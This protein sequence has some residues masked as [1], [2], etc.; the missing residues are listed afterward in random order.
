MIGRTLSHYRILD[1]IGRGGMGAVYRARDTKLD[2]DVAIKV[3]P[4]DLM[5]DEMRRLRFV[6]EAKAAAAI[7]NPHVATIHEIDEA[8]GVH[9]LVM[10]FIS[11]E[12]L[13]DVL[14]RE[15][16]PVSRTLELVTELAE[17]L[18]KAHEKRVV[19]RDL[20]PANVMLTEDGHIKIIDFGLAKLLESVR[21]LVSG[22]SE[23]ETGY[24]GETH[25][26]QIL[27]TV[28]YM[29]P[30]QAR[31]E[32]VDHRSD[33]FSF[34]I[35]FYEMLTGSVPFKGKSG[36]D[37][38]SAI[39]R[40]PTPRLSG[41]EHAEELQH[42]MN[43]CLAKDPEERYQTTK[44]LLADIRRIKR[45]AESGVRRVVAK[46]A[47]GRVLWSIVAAALILAA[48][49]VMFW[50]SA[51][52]EY[53]P[54]VGRTIQV[55][56]DPGLE[57]DASIS[58]DGK[59]VA[60]AAGPLFDTKIFVKQ[61]AGG[62]SVPLTVDLDG[63]HRWPRWS[64]DGSQLSF[65][66]LSSQG[67]E[68][69]IVPALG[70]AARRHP[71]PEET[72]ELAWSPDGRRVA[73][74]AWE[75]IY[76]GSDDGSEARKLV[77]VRDEPW[78]I[79]WSPDGK[80]IAFTSGNP[81]YRLNLNV[82]PSSIVVVDVATGETIPVTDQ[83]HQNVSPI[84]LPDGRSLLYVSDRGGVRDVYRVSISDSGRPSGEPE[85]LTTGLDV[86]TISASGDGRT[87]AY[88]I[89]RLR[90]NLWSMPVPEKGPVSVKQAMP[91]TTGNQVIE[92]VGVSP[93]GKW[94]VYDL[95]LGG[96]V[97]LYKLRVGSSESVQ[98]TR[99]PMD[100]YPTW[101]P[102]AIEIAFHAMRTDNR[103]IFI[104]G[105]DGGPVRQLTNDRAQ[106][107]Y[108]HWS[109]DGTKVVFHST[110][111]D[112]SNDVYVVSK[113]MG[114]PAGEIP[115]QLTFGAGA[116]SPRWSPDGRHIAYFSEGV[117][118]I[119]AEGGTPRRI[120]NFGNRPMWSK[121]SRTIYFREAPPSERAGIWSV[122]LSGGDPQLCVVFDDPT[123][124]PYFPEWSSDG[125]TFYFTL[126][127]FESDV[128]VMEFEES[129]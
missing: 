28:S 113:E 63:R 105:A 45:D 7:H 41:V 95:N 43:R 48:L 22:E 70:G 92:A 24:R 90:Q 79:S 47:R 109:P 117:S 64:P 8:D 30:E 65:R 119:P 55:T 2:R 42:V 10:E 76:V 114:E 118:V 87:L 60:Y 54:R 23:A 46:P 17:G 94:L 25:P 116:T 101:S 66:R 61:V 108:P 36:T 88:S 32:A 104:V 78:S 34:G 3:L 124:Q 5:A 69:Y 12:K 127:E 102:D 111:N 62:R 58:P 91:V 72:L 81:G 13:S 107:F 112:H 83:S 71:I 49:G 57:L 128:W 31:G 14:A 59:L 126:T 56:R 121:D 15:R 75:A 97:S 18:S 67:W 86:F 98:V 103:D 40:D 26:G 122:S 125:E 96:N 20:K 19:H 129:E 21:P 120:T 44:D 52:G 123:R 38:L 51:P 39:L 68:I 106:E 35:V 1:E 33:L 110:R 100:F 82:A 84:W 16:L 37:I 9:F 99:G 27:G 74:A 50:P 29:S 93:D 89:A 73:Y 53:A 85:R 4:F 115:V 6:Q 77:D 80:R 11:G